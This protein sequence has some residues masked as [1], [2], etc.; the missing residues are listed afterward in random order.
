VREAVQL[1]YGTEGGQLTR[2]HKH[3]L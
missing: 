3:I 1:D 2:V